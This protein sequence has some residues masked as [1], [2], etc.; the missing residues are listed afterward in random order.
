MPKMHLLLRALAVKEDL[1]WATSKSISLAPED[2]EYSIVETDVLL[3]N[4][5]AKINVGFYLTMGP[6]QNGGGHVTFH[7]YANDGAALS[8]LEEG[9]FY[10]ATRPSRARGISGATA[11]ARRLKQLVFLLTGGE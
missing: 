1:T 4:S 10:M 5:E 7:S 9:G 8:S 6:I 3:V 11:Q 2:F